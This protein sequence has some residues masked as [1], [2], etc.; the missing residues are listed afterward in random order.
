VPDK[1]L[2]DALALARGSI[3]RAAE[4]REDIA[5]LEA[6][7]G[8]ESSRVLVI[9]HGRAAA[10]VQAD[11]GGARGSASLHYLPPSQAPDGGV[12]VLLAVVEGTAYLGVLLDVAEDAPP[13]PQGTVWLG[14][15]ELGA[16]LGDVDA[17]V[18]V[19]AVAL[20]NWHASHPRCPRCGVPTVPSQAGWSRTCPDDESQHFPRSDPAVIV[21]VRDAD[22]RALLGRRMEWPAG[23]FSTL[24]GFVEA[25]ESAEAAV[26]RELSEEAGVDVDPGA[27]D[28]LGSQPWPFP[29]SLMLGYH[30][31]LAPG[32]RVAIPDGVEI[33]EVRW[34]S[35]AEMLEACRTGELRIPPAVS[36]ARRLVEAW[37]GG[38]LPGEWSRP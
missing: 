18:M 31:R 36:I 14:L 20:A 35:R 23:F 24:A 11:A 12:R 7:W 29:S 16:A 26:L 8:D 30:A 34:F 10:V 4:R 28:Y 9:H 6:A 13:E 5:W 32:S 15:R 33:E 17:S 22:D 2:L 1:G 19:A 27:L 38:E 3:D 21:L 37:Y 25:G